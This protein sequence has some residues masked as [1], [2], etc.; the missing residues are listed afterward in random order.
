MD[1]QAAELTPPDFVESAQLGPSKVPASRIRG[2]PFGAVLGLI[3]GLAFLLTAKGSLR[4]V[5]IYWH[6]LA[7]RQILD[8]VPVG[9]LGLDWSFAPSPLPWTSTQW[10]GEG[11]L[12]WLYTLGGWS[13]LAAF[14]VV[15]AV[16]AIAVL[17]LTTIRGRPVLLAAM[18]YSVG[19]IAVAAYSQERTQQVS[20]IGAA[21]LGGVLV[22]GLFV[23]QL[24][25]WWLLL[26]A[27][28]LWAN[29]HG[30]WI[31]VPAVL[32]MIALGRW[33]D[34]GLRDALGRQALRLAAL[35]ILAGALSPGGLGNVTAVF[36]IQRATDVIQEWSAVT[37]TEDV[38]ILS[39]ILLCI[40]LVAWS[41]G[42][43][44]PRSEVLST[45]MLLVF[46]WIAWRNLILAILMVI[47]LITRRLSESFPAVARRQEPRWSTPLGMAISTCF[48]VVALASVHG[49]AHLPTTEYPISLAMRLA[50]MPQQQRVLND[51]DIAGM[52]LLFGDGNAQVGIDGRTDRYGPEYIEAYTGMAK[53]N[54]GWRELLAELDPTFALIKEDSALAQV[55]E[56]SR[57][58]VR[59]GSESGYV[60]LKAP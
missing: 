51:Y 35:S 60:L 50:D 27:T 25:R 18:P 9:Q 22:T 42:R 28:V 17:A 49:A 43:R 57:G 54:G 3:T 30:A 13:A 23:G 32:A 19:V 39:L 21:A 8:G 12:A 16:I 6:V 10:L 29:I 59:V 36:R 11:I 52:V 41:V 1:E 53:L 14:R 37:P 33:A 38:G 44:I 15:T 7:G 4:D 47:P 26:P 55:L 45:I 5:D 56:E 24:P 34:H 48:T 20:F 58:W 31:L 46:G 40:L 2:L